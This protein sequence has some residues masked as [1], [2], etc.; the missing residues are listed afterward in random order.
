MAPNRIRRRVSPNPAAAITLSD[1][2]RPR[3]PRE[4]RLESS[5]NNPL[6][7]AESDLLGQL[8]VCALFL[9]VH[10][11]PLGRCDNHLER[12]AR[13]VVMRIRVT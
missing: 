9:D 13:K 7:S 6:A 10:L 5:P 12:P 2:G 4:I 1:C 3:L 11:I 8:V